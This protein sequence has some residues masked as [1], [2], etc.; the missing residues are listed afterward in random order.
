MKSMNA[1]PLIVLA[2]MTASGISFAEEN[3]LPNTPS[4]FGEDVAFLKKHT[5]VV[6]LSLIHI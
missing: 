5:E 3:K 2:M 6:V 4:N 1:H